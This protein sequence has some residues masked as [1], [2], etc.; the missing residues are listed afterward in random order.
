MVFEHATEHVSQWAAI[1]SISEQ[2]RFP[3]FDNYRL[4]VLYRCS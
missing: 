4:R 3:N 1:M 2:L